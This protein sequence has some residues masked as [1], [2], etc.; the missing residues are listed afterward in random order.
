MFRWDVTRRGAGLAARAWQRSTASV[1]QL[2]QWQEKSVVEKEGG[3]GEEKKDKR[4]GRGAEVQ[5][6]RTGAAA[7]IRINA[8]FL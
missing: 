4:W 8:R 3:E 7:G 5:G 6:R 2:Q 1:E